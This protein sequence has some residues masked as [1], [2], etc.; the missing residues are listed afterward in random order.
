MGP[1]QLDARVWCGLAAEYLLWYFRHLL[2]HIT[3]PPGPP[4]L[5][6]LGAISV[7][8]EPANPL[9]YPVRRGLQRTALIRRTVYVDAGQM[10]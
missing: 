3:P 1:V 9:P 10:R 4:L 5:A 7:C 2:L 8:V 6:V